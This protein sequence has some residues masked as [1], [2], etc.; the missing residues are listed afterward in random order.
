MIQR[1][2]ADVL[3]L[4]HLAFIVFVVAGG[5]LVLR[6]RWVALVHLPAAVWGAYVEIS[7][8]GCPLTR[9][10][11]SLR[12]AGG[13]AGYSGGFIQHYIVPVIYPGPMP[14]WVQLALAALVV[15]VN[16]LVYFVVV[17]R[18]LHVPAGSDDTR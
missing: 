8:S 18:R 7:A 9:F 17:R 14:R 12:R 1:I 3:V 16:V 15:L 13:E 2:M 11:N 10:E 5:L 6:R 4:L